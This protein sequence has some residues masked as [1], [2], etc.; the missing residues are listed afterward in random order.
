[1]E[2]VPLGGEDADLIRLLADDAAGRL[3]TT[4]PAEQRSAIRAHVIDERGYGDIANDL[5]VGEP[6][7][8]QRVSRGLAALRGR[9][10]GRR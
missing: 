4:L 3:L 1:M 5:Q 10:G 8:R 2:R 6:V 9:I 7:V